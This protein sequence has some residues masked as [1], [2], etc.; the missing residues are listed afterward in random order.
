[1]FDKAFQMP[2]SLFWETQYRMVHKEVCH[3]YFLLN[4][5]TKG[6]CHLA[7]DVPGKCFK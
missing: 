4:K 3:P 1:M 5:G 2:I 6:K 7:S